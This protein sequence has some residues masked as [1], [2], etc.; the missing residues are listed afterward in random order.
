M[1]VMNAAA[2]DVVAFIA[3]HPVRFLYHTA[4]SN[5]RLEWAKKFD[6]WPSKEP[7]FVSCRR[8][9]LTGLVIWLTTSIVD[10]DATVS[11]TSL[12]PGRGRGPAIQMKARL[13][14]PK[15]QQ[16]FSGLMFVF[17]ILLLASGCATPVGV[18]RLNEQEAHRELNANVLSTGEPSAY[19]TQILERTALAQRY[20]S[21]PQEVIAELNSGLGKPEERDRLFALSELSFAYAEDSGNRP[22]YLASAAYAYAFLFPPDPA[23]APGEY[24]R[25]LHMAVDLYNRGIALGLTTSDGTVVDLDARQFSL[26]FGS[27]AL[28]SSPDGFTYAG[29]HLT[30]FVSLADM[31]VRGL[32][33]VYR[34]AGIGAALSAKV[35][36]SPNNPDELLG[37]PAVASR[38]EI[39]FFIY[40]S[41]NPIALSAMRLRESLEAVRKD[42]DPD[43]KDP[44]LDN[45]DASNPFLKTL[46]SLPIAKGVDAHS[47]IPVRGTG[48]V[49]EGNDG[50]VEYSSAH[51]DGVASELIVRSGHSTQGTPATIEEVRRI[52]YAHA[53]IH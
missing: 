37:D 28:A 45:M 34:I 11:M 36:P 53:G 8:S 48:P 16:S 52:L 30:N 15:L 44:A 19:S 39:W 43:G 33:N 25:R 41:G 51:I 5:G 31:K 38:Y 49:E 42:V 35:E 26:P 40:N 3:I 50:V 12:R 47:I 20:Q 32:R 46:A 1:V 9:A 4:T 2:I 17:A 7:P 23:N 10:T 24:D 22:Y 14:R 21:Q 27:L 13:V 6:N 18:S 29:Y